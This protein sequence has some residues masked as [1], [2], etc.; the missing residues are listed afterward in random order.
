M[1]PVALPPCRS[2]CDL[3]LTL[4]A[5]VPLTVPQRK[6]VLGAVGPRLLPE[7]MVGRATVPAPWA[8]ISML[9]PTTVLPVT[10]PF[11]MLGRARGRVPRVRAELDPEVARRRAHHRVS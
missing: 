7:M 6:V 4:R 2:T 5:L 8:L 1:L 10:L 11:S 9:P 3:G